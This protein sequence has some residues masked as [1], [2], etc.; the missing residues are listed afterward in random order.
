MVF[1]SLQV[2]IEVQDTN[3]HIPQTQ[4]AS[5]HPFVRED[6]SIGTPVVTLKA[7]DGDLAPANISFSLSKIRA[8]RSYI[9]GTFRSDNHAFNINPTTGKSSSFGLLFCM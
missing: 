4:E 1:F 8:R 9:E 6:A 2:Y 5:Y 3:D 7:Y